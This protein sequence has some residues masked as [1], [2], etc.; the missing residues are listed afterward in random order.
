MSGIER[1]GPFD[2]F[3]RGLCYFPGS[4]PK[5]L[6]RVLRTMTDWVKLNTGMG[7]AGGG[8]TLL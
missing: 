4:G 8:L 1:V 6:N 7:Q 3:I 5:A 2:R